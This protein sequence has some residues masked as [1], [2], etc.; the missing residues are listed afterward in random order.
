MKKIVLF[1]A[2]FLLGITCFC[3]EKQYVVV[4][5]MDGFRWDYDSLA[6]TPNLD[7]IAKKGV[8]SR[9]LQP[10]FPTLTF[11][12]HYSMATGLY[13]DNHGLIANRFYN[14]K[15]GKYNPEKSQEAAFYNGEPI[16]NTAKKQGIKTANFFWIGSEAPI[17][18]MLP[19]I[20]K[21]YE[22][23]KKTTYS[24]RIDSMMSWLD[25]PE[26]K[27]PQLIM[28]YFE[29]PDKTTHKNDPDPRKSGTTRKIVEH[30]DSL[31]GVLDKKIQALPFAKNIH[32]IVLSDHGMCSVDSGRTVHLSDYLKES[33]IDSNSYF[34]TPLSLVNIH[35][36]KLD[37]A[38]MALKNAKH[39][40]VWKASDMPE[41]LHYGKNPNIGNLVIL[42]DSA[43]NISKDKNV[44][45][46]GAH[47][48]DNQNHDMYGIFYAYGPK[49]K[50]DT[51]VEEFPNIQLYN[52]IAHLLNLKN[53]VKTDADL[54]DVEFLFKDK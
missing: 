39:I 8:K 2:L 45:L 24:Q 9:G 23:D 50:K 34:D 31:V 11:P 13:P 15:L 30:C 48:F 27:R 47:G 54:K 26:E 36:D 38:I 29:D 42:A 19:D 32:L 49:F 41:R 33:W 1:T 43:W 25:L 12:N 4:L 20:Y 40:S 52:I 37:S 22:K 51:I 17:D 3:Q 28:F 7:K 18:G 21:I 53:P 44:D 14:K 16:W 35:P 6:S 5:S 10:C 46:K